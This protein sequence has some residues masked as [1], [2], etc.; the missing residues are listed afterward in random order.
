MNILKSTTAKGKL[1]SLDVENLFTNVPVNETK[2]IIIN[3]S[4]NRP[5]IKP[6]VIPKATLKQLL[7]TCTTETPFVHIDGSVFVQVDGVSMGSPLSPMFSNFYMANL[8]NESF[9]DPNSNLKPPVYCRYVDD[10]FIIIENDQKL[11]AIKQHFENNS[12]LNSHMNYTT[13]KLNSLLRCQDF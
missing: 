11:D 1:A 3:R 2:D 9:E 12:V 5:T 4:Y 8:E 6:P 13:S 7:K 10:I